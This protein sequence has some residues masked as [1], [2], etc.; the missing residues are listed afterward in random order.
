MATPTSAPTWP[1]PEAA[2]RK[3]LQPAWKTQDPHVKA[4]LAQLPPI[5]DQH[6]SKVKQLAAARGAGDD[7]GNSNTDHPLSPARAAHPLNPLNP[8]PLHPGMP[9]RK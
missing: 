6:L 1:A 3:L 2:S 4:L 9:E 7:P 5:V 8:A